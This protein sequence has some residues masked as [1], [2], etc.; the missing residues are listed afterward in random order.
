M[1]GPVGS[2]DGGGSPAQAPTSE[3]RASGEH[4]ATRIGRSSHRPQAYGEDRVR[5]RRRVGRARCVPAPGTAVPE[6]CARCA[7]PSTPLDSGRRV[8]LPL[9]DAEAYCSAYADPRSNRGYNLG[10]RSR[11]RNRTLSRGGSRE[12]S[13][14]QVTSRVTGS[15]AIGPGRPLGRQ[16]SSL[17]WS[18]ASSH[19]RHRSPS[20]YPG[21]D[22]ASYG[23]RP[24][25]R[26]G[27][28]RS[29][30]IAPGGWRD[31]RSRGRRGRPG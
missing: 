14:I 4:E 19:Q 11:I 23:R 16:R 29:G 27:L 31:G 8:P 9:A 15:S 10:R 7:R 26:S 20:G 21:G 22:L 30:R 1:H 6:W 17:S 13:R 24:V 18:R 3:R 5:R 12:G 25:R 2:N 28:R